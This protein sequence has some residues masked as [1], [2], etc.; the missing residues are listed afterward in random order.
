MRDQYN[1]LGW[2]QSLAPAARTATVNGT[3]VDIRDYDSA[4]LVLD[5]GTF[6][7]TTPTATFRWEESDDNVTFTAI[8]AA[9]L[10]GGLIAGIDT[11]N[12]EQVYKRG[13]L[14]LKRYIRG[15][16]TAIAGTGPSLPCAAQVVRGNAHQ[17]PVA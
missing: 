8:A 10:L 2:S 16:I 1:H 11:T 7:G 5:L 17:K 6:A 15:A 4:T 14:G 9:D 13:Y 12:D 3:G